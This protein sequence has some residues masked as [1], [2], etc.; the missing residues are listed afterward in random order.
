MTTFLPTHL[1]DEIHVTYRVILIG[2]KK[3]SK[4]SESLL[5]AMQVALNLPAH[6]KSTASAVRNK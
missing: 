5:L 3:L 6:F 4:Y 1:S 2:A